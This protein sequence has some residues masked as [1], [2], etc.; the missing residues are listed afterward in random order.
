MKSN[1]FNKE[2]DYIKDDRIKQN[3]RI[4]IDNLPDYF[5]T[6]QAASTGKY[7]PTYALGEKG[8]IRHTKAAV[9]F[10]N[11]LFGIYKFEE[12]TKDLIILSILI[13]DGLKKGFTEEKYTRFDHPVLIGELLKMDQIE[14]DMKI[15]NYNAMEDH[16]L[17][18]DEIFTFFY[19][20]LWNIK[21]RLLTLL[22][23]KS[24]K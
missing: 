7:H 13:H 17:N 3:A 19:E 6:I 20:D 24:N 23:L 22:I 5:F 4:I 2:L 10:A 8:L 9:Y 21:N 14:N 12:A 16:E 1:I 18:E 11:T 15:K